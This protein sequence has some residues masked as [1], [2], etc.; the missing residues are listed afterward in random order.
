MTI[1]DY[2]ELSTFGKIL[3]A[4][5]KAGRTSITTVQQALSLGKIT[6]DEY[7]FI[8]LSEWLKMAITTYEELSTFA[9]I[10]YASYKDKKSVESTAN[11]AATQYKITAAEKTFILG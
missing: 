1:V 4:S 9:K 2:E 8:T 11:M 7:D 3:Y 10:L 5:Y 6:Q